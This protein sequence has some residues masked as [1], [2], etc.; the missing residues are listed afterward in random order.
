MLAWNRVR[1]ACHDA[2][3]AAVCSPL[4]PRGARQAPD[5]TRRRGNVRRRRDRQSVACSAERLLDYLLGLVVGRRPALLHPLVLGDL[6]AL[7]V[8]EQLHGKPCWCLV[9]FES[10]LKA[11]R[12]EV[13][14]VAIVGLAHLGVPPR[15]T[16]AARADM[17]HVAIEDRVPGLI[18]DL[19]KR[20]STVWLAAPERGSVQLPH[21]R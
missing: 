3:E 4:L 1:I 9:D 19:E 16:F 18:I 17:R 20:T 8:V 6:P 10:V 12:D 15:S 7:P 13:G 21:R 5:R 14:R 2:A 11:H